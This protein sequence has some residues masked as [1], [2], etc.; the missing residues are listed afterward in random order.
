ML[1]RKFMLKLIRRH[2]NCVKTTLKENNKKD[3]MKFCLSMLDEATKTIAM[4]KFK[5]M[6]N[7]V[8][9]DETWFNMTNKNKTYYLLDGEEEPTR[10]IH[11][12]CIGKVM[13]LTSAARPRWD[14]EGN[15]TFSEKIGILPFVKEVPAQR[16]C[17]NR[18][19]G[20]I[21]TKSIEV[22][23]KVMREFLIEKVLPAIQA[24]WPESDVG[25]IIY[26]QQDNACVEALM[27]LLSLRCLC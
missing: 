18:P 3:R 4:P 7:V 2:A 13:F 9:I 16:R 8:H 10:P 27:M 6:H 19:R 1:H 15:V 23:K 17:D 26:I 20:T 21:E 11:G 25:Q 5:T 24:V 22:G 12:S 14:S